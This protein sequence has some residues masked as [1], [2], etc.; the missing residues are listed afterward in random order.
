MIFIMIALLPLWV[1]GIYQQQDLTAELPSQSP[2]KTRPTSQNPNV[3]LSLNP[4]IP[5]PLPNLNQGYL[6]NS[7]RFRKS[8]TTSSTNG[9][10]P[11]IN[12]DS[13]QY[14]GSII[15]GTTRKALISYTDGKTARTASRTN[16]TANRLR[17]PTKD[18]RISKIISLGE[19]IGGY[20]VSEVEP[21]QVTFTRGSHT[22]TKDLFSTDKKRSAPAGKNIRKIA[23]SRA[24]QTARRINKTVP[25]KDDAP[26]RK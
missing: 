17:T 20:T 26:V 13:L 14:N 5:S 11:K 16:K 2:K 15:V 18:R 4:K 9:N 23:Q 22:V 21:L 6:F 19:T 12:M 3:V 25:P 7:E 1:L 10:D 8:S 24:R